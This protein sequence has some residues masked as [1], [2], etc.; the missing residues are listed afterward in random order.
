MTQSEKDQIIM[1]NT[2]FIHFAMHKYFPNF[3]KI[4][5]DLYH[6][7]IVATLEVL[8]DY[9]PSKGSLTT[10]LTPYLLHSASTY[11]ACYVFHTTLYYHRILAQIFHSCALIVEDPLTFPIKEI[12]KCSKLSE[13][14]VENALKQYRSGK[15]LSYDSDMSSASY[16][17]NDSYILKEELSKAVHSSL[18]QLDALDQLIIRCRFGF[19]DHSP[20]EIKEIALNLSLSQ[21]F[22]TARLEKSLKILKENPVLQSFA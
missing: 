8:D 5:E 16:T 10:F 11:I 15:Y 12:S 18:N 20:M 6:E 2:N 17:M 1:D 19:D 4:H 21:T 7:G 13:R 14:T 3:K 9:N 22:V